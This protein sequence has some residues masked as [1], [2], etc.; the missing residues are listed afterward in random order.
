VKIL[1]FI[2][3]TF[4]VL[5]FSNNYT[6]EPEI[7]TN[8]VVAPKVLNTPIPEITKD[9]PQEIKDLVELIFALERYKLDYRAYP[10]SSN[11][12]KA[13]D[14]LRSNYGESRL[15]WI[16]GLVP[17]YINALPQDPRRLNDGTKQ[18]LYISN[19]ANY[20][21]IAHMAGNCELIKARYPSMVDPTRETYAYG[22]WSFGA[23]WW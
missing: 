3:F 21:L 17:V 15:D 7:N 5:L 8:L 12:G 2:F 10:I 9:T 13:W 19:G 14:G 22:F 20:K 23:G 1:F 16:Q 11:N 4:G 6:S 18:Y